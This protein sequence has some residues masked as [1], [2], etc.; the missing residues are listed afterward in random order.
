M[1]GEDLRLRTFQRR[2]H[3]LPIYY[4][5]VVKLVPQLQLCH[6]LQEVKEMERGVCYK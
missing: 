5:A 2:D 3:D 4:G 1:M 6:F